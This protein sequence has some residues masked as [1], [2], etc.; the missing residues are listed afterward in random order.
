MKYLYLI[1]HAKSSWDYP[2]LTDIERPLNSRGEKDA[3]MMGKRLSAMGI[4]PDLIMT[5]PAK[6][7]LQTAKK[8]AKET[9]YPV[10]NIIINNNLYLAGVTTLLKTIRAI[11]ERYETVFMF[12]HNPEF[13]TLANLLTLQQ[14]Y[15]IPTC[16]ICNISFEID[17][18]RLVTEGTGKLILNDYPKKSPD[19]K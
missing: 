10:N 15:N 17:S 9:G 19:N 13:T 18:W 5:S 2:N 14:I 12:G 4:K 3:P 11:N 8:I 16:G 6:R 1:R 7:A